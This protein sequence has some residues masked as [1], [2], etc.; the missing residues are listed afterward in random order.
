[1]R[2]LIV[3]VV[4]AG[5]KIHKVKQVFNAQLHLFQVEPA[6]AVRRLIA[7][8]PDVVDTR[9]QAV[10]HQVT[11]FARRDKHRQRVLIGHAQVGVNG[12]HPFDGK[13]QRPAAVERTRRKVDM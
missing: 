2:L 8:T 3:T 11:E 13:L 4:A 9:H 12:I 5:D 6:V 7:D 1:M 10:V